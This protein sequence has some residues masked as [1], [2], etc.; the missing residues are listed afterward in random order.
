MQGFGNFRNIDHIIFIFG[1]NVPLVKQFEK[2]GE[3]CVFQH[4]LPWKKVV[5][6]R[7]VCVQLLFNTSCCPN[8]MKFH[9]TGVLW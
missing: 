7:K 2:M 4:R 8:P 1:H 5:H 6:L 3:K 9:F